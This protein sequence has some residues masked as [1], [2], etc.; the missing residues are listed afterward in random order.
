MYI[1]IYTYIY[2]YAYIYM[3][4]YIY[5]YISTHIYIYIYMHTY[6]Y[7]YTYIYIYIHIHIY[8]HI[9]IHTYIYATIHLARTPAS[10]DEV[11]CARGGRVAVPL[12]ALRNCW[13]FSKVN[14]I[15]NRLQKML[16]DKYWLTAENSWEILCARQHYKRHS[17]NGEVSE[18]S[19]H[20]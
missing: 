8:I 14:S 13:I 7:M 20:N 18:K 2:M 3:Y 16:I 1:Y 17:G 11:G 19:A 4:M 12:K 15:L 5:I 6:I 9:Y 10:T